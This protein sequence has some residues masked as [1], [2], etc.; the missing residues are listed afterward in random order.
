MVRDG[1]NGPRSGKSRWSER[2]ADP[3]SASTLRYSSE[4]GRSAPPVRSSGVFQAARGA[5]LCRRRLSVGVCLPSQDLGWI[6]GL[7][8]IRAFSPWS[9]CRSLERL[10]QTIGLSATLRR[11]RQRDGHAPTLPSRNSR[12]P[13]ALSGAVNNTRESHR[14]SRPAV[15]ATTK[16]SSNNVNSTLSIVVSQFL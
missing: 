9:A 15:A 6:L 13:I 1:A 8:E 3:A 16:P 7:E 10:L 12:S 5:S 2:I 11:H 14:D 4:T